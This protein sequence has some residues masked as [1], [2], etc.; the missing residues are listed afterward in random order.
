MANPTLDD[1]DFIYRFRTGDNDAIAALH[2]Y[3]IKHFIP[4]FCW[5]GFSYVDAQDLWS[6]TQLDLL[7]RKCPSYDPSQGPFRPWLRKV[8]KR[9]AL[10][11]L[12]QRKRHPHISL[13]ECENM[14]NPDNHP[15][16]EKSG[17]S[18]VTIKLERAR[19]LLSESDRSIISQRFDE[20]LSIDLIAEGHNISQPAARMRLW[21]AVQK[22]RQILEGLISGELPRRRKAIRRRNPRRAPAPEGG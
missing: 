20:G 12:R 9:V 18:E 15:E 7:K 16:E 13:A 21:R 19:E 2:E 22:L 6:E 11:K 3:G 17:K 1:A 4:H 10:Y 14:R 5:I 8:A